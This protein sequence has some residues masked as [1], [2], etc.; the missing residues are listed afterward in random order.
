MGP[1]VKSMGSGFGESGIKDL[2]PF[3][4]VSRLSGV[5]LWK[6]GSVGIGPPKERVT[7]EPRVLQYTSLVMSFAYADSAGTLG[8]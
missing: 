3:I 7:V 6:E 1:V 2:F 4:L 5:F 8:Q